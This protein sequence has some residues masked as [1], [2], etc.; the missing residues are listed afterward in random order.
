MVRKQTNKRIKKTANQNLRA[1]YLT[2]FAIFILVLAGLNIVVYVS[3]QKTFTVQAK[4]NTPLLQSYYLKK[5]LSS[6]PTY[7]EGWVALAKLEYS[8]GNMAEVQMAITKV[9]EIDPNDKELANLQS[10][11][12][13]K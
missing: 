12:S 9:R 2:L 8:L 11:L 6:H 7:R 10:L 3:P 1:F 5:L 4:D 13:S